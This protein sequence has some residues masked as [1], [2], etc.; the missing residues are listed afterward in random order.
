MRGL[1][2]YFK[3]IFSENLVFGVMAIEK[4]PIAWKITLGV[5]DLA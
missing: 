2:P 3:K 5:I 1:T 4:L